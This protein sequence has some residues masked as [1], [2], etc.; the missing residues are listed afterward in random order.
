MSIDKTQASDSG[1]Q[2]PLTDRGERRF[3]QLVIAGGFGLAL[4][5]AWA[6]AAPWLVTLIALVLVAG[7]ISPGWSLTRQVPSLLH[8]TVGARRTKRARN[9]VPARGR[10]PRSHRLRGRGLHNR[11]RPARSAGLSSA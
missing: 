3:H 5:I 9:L 8:S 6:K 4:I 10:P 2:L 11:R 7:S 1:G